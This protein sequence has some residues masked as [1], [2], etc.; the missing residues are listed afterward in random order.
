MCLR[1]NNVLSKVFLFITLFLG[2]EACNEKDLD[3]EVIETACQDFFIQDAQYQFDLTPSCGDEEINISFNYTGDE[4][5][6]HLVE[7]APVFYDINGAEIADFDVASL[8]IVKDDLVISNGKISLEYCLSYPNESAKSDLNYIQFDVHTENEQANESN[9]IGLRA[10][11]PGKSVKQPNNSDFE[12]EFVVNKL[13]L[14]I[15]VF[16]D[17]AEDGDIISINANNE[18]LI[19]NKMIFKAGETLLF[20]IEAKENNFLLLYAVNEGSSSPNTLAGTIDDGVTIQSFN[21]NLKTGEQVY[22][23][24]KYVAPLEGI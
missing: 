14:K 13:N 2:V 11:L 15:N 3:L 16:D 7:L 17:A 12:K 19:E 5:C 8:E 9:T 10:N 23:K 1:R 21:L 4:E 18:W 22:F 6:V 20:T 24:V